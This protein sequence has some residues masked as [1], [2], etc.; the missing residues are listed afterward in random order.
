MLRR[1]ADNYLEVVEIK[2]P[3]KEPL[4]RHDPSH[5]SYAPGSALS[6]AIGQV[7]NYID[8]IERN[9][10][11]IIA[12]DGC[13]PSK[14]R[15]RIIIGSDGDLNQQ[16][17]LRNLNGHLHRIEVITFDQLLR[18]ADRVLAIFSTELQRKTES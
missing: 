18:I 10:D 9:R 1:T 2:T 6:L 17:A 15:A 14:I 7:V 8:A 13:D 16:A 11:G 12:K 5:D 3:L 4:F